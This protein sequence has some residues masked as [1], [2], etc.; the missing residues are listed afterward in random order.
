MEILSP[1]YSLSSDPMKLVMGD[2]Q[3]VHQSRDH[4]DG[5]AQIAHADRVVQKLLVQV[6]DEI[7]LE[8]LRFLGKLIGPLLE[9]AMN[10]I[11]INSAPQRNLH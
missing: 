10:E 6:L 11:L 9:V 1:P 7:V 8:V 4:V 3:L 5:P 2:F